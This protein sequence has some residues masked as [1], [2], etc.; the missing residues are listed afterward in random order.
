MKKKDT[1]FMIERKGQGFG[2]WV[3][4]IVSLESLAWQF[5]FPSFVLFS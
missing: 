4:G 5:V 3:Y 2:L 1:H